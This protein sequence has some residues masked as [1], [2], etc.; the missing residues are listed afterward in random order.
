MLRQ[1]DIANAYLHREI[2]LRTPSSRTTVS[3]ARRQAF[4]EAAE[5]YSACAGATPLARERLAYYRN[6]ALCFTEAL[7][8]K[9]AGKAYILAEEYT[10]AAQAF[11]QGGYFDEA[12]DTIHTYD[13][14]IRS[15][16]ANKILDVAKIHYC[17][18]LNLE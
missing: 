15:V 16:D 17:K 11:R 8:I 12:V 10:K 14:Q 3:N 1:R 18:G 4:L 13:T 6:A 7:E 2:A 5:A 9:R